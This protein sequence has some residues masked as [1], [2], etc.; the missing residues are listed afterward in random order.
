MKKAR[1]SIATN[2]TNSVHFSGDRDRV[3]T[4]KNIGN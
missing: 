1:G 2:N 3:F 4:P